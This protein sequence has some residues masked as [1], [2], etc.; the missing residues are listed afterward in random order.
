MSRETAVCGH[1]PS[2]T[3]HANVQ[4]MR[5]RKMN[6]A[7][8]VSLHLCLAFVSVWGG[9][10]SAQ[11]NPAD[12]AYTLLPGSLLLDDCPICDH[13]PIPMPI[14][15]TFQLHVKEVNPLFATYE[16][17]D[18]ALH[19]D[20]GAGRQYIVNGSG[21]YRYGGPMAVIQDTF[22][23]IT[24]DD[25]FHKTLCYCTNLTGGTGTVWPELQLDVAQTNGTPSRVYHLKIIALPAPRFIAITPDFQVGNIRLDWAAN[26]QKVQVEKAEDA[27]GPYI[28]LSPVTTDQTYTDVGALGN[29]THSYYR[30]RQW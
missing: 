25:G 17:L 14:Q 29:R 26:G 24:V 4:R 22:L 21:T 12:V 7:T 23:N 5:K 3:E 8:H 1:L 6:W 10:G 28:A 30:L 19:T 20:Q 2:R 16:L 18:I 9:Q 13:V 15:G 27:S 11:T